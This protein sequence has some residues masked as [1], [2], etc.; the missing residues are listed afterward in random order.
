M[1][2]T[3]STQ[4]TQC[5]T[6]SA[7]GSRRAPGPRAAPLPAER[8]RRRQGL[9]PERGQRH[10]EHERRLRGRGRS[11]AGLADAAPASGPR[12]AG[13]HFQPS[14][15]ASAI[16]SPTSVIEPGDDDGAGAGTRRPNRGRRSTA[17]SSGVELLHDDPPRPRARRD[18]RAP[19]AGIARSE[20]ERGDVEP[21]RR[22]G[23]RTV[24]D[25]LGV[26]VGRGCRPRSTISS[27]SK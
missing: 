7:A 6:G 15:A 27:K 13:H 24:E 11:R 17:S 8:E 23:E 12:L 16:A 5:P 1:S 4:P 26:L 25:A 19:G 21:R 3:C 14:R 2:T 9:Q 22:S 20:C 10:E 18:R